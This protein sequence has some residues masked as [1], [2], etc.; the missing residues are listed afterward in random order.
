MARKAQAAGQDQTKAP[1]V[2]RARFINAAEGRV[3]K[4]L[5]AISH[6]GG[7]STPNYDYEQ[8]DVDDIVDALQAEVRHMKRTLE[9]GIKRRAKLFTE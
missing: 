4:A 8:K 2:R 5:T 1:T 3:N 7:M 6:I 9:S